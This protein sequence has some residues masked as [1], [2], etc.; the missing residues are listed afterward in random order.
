MSMAESFYEAFKPYFPWEVNK[1]VTRLETMMAAFADELAA[2]DAATNDIAA[3]LESL[4]DQIASAD[5][6]AAAQLDPLVQR[7]R[8]LASDPSNPVP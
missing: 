8:S 4:R 1:R 7:L 3:E 5:A 2:L 6:N